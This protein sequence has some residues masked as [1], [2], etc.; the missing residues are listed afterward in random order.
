MKKIL[1]VLMLSIFFVIYS[2]HESKAV[3]N[4]KN[5]IAE[6]SLEDAQKYI[7]NKNNINAIDVNGTTALMS[8]AKDGNILAVTYL[9][10]NGALIAMYDFFDKSAL[11]LAS[12]EGHKEVIKILLA[13]GADVNT[14]QNNE[15]GATALIMASN[16]GHA[17]IVKILLD[18]GADVNAQSESEGVYGPALIEA[19]GNGHIDVAKILVDA[20]ADVNAIHNNALGD[21]ALMRASREGKI[22]LVKY[23]I[24]NGAHLE[25]KDS[26]GYTAWIHATLNGHTE[27]VEYLVE[28]GADLTIE[29]RG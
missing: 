29:N 12:E 9:L 23:L 20:G 26:Q 4:I 14:I 7:I 11:L 25:T 2:A 24:E 22:E 17:E 19:S 16:R 18:G 15:L 8:A 3:E 10:E 21:T 1:C 5:N 13:A 27:V 6:A 28:Q